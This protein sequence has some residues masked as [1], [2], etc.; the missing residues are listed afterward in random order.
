MAVL[1]SKVVDDTRYEVRTAG[2]SL[3]LY[4]N[5][6]FHSQY[7][8]DS[9]ASGS[10]WDLLFLPAYLSNPATIKNVLVL[11]VGGGAVVRQLQHFLHPT[12]ITGVEL[13]PM[14]LYI[15][16]RFFKI[17]RPNTYLYEHD[18]VHWL[19]SYQGPKFDYIVDDLFSDASG[20]PER[21]VEADHGWFSLLL[22][23]LSSNGVLVMNFVSAKE[24][25][26]SAF[27][28]NRLVK[29]QFR[30]AFKLETPSNE[31]AIAAFLKTASSTKALLRNLSAP[32]L[33][34]VL[35]NYP[36]KYRIRAISM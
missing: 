7:N 4:T 33:H 9:P 8:A 32:E 5:G 13:D 20:E 10:V 34:A 25:K 11:G 19:R 1:W 16:K 2:K 26:R 35:R 27:F 23:H 31:N 21:A 22:K 30:S 29:S 15:A 18:A 28:S 24:L 12:R 36:E 17:N 6:V 14:H 3:R